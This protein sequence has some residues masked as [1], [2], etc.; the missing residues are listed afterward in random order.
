M[1]GPRS[2]SHAAAKP[3]TTTPMKTLKNFNIVNP[4]LCL[5]RPSVLVANANTERRGFARL[6][7]LCGRQ[8]EIPRD[9]IGSV[10][11]IASPQRECPGHACGRRQRKVRVGQPV[12]RHGKVV[13]AQ[14]IKLT[15]GIMEAVVRFG[16]HF[17]V[18]DV[19]CVAGIAAVTPLRYAFGLAVVI[20]RR[21]IPV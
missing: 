21:S 2:F 4:W 11:N 18:A 19:E 17:E 12:A 15:V 9:I 14:Q 20:D 5:A 1:S 7:D 8:E 6:R 13:A 16:G 10:E 3:N